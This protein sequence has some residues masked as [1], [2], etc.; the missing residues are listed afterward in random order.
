MLQGGQCVLQGR[1]SLVRGC[2]FGHGGRQGSQNGV[3]H[4]QFQQLVVQ[5]IA[6]GQN[7][8]PQG[9]RPY[10]GGGALVPIGADSKYNGQ[11]QRQAYA[12]F[13][14]AAGMLCHNSSPLS[15][16]VWAERGACKL[17]FW[18]RT[19]GGPSRGGRHGWACRHRP[20]CSPFSARRRHC[21]RRSR[22]QKC[23]TP[24]R[25]CRSSGP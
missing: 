23:Q 21:G 16:G 25:R 22:R 15:T 18:H 11:C 13:Q 6:V 1:S 12:Q 17:I 9:V 10:L 5:R 14:H 24:P 3:P 20:A 19:R 4:L 8:Q 7:M 2:C